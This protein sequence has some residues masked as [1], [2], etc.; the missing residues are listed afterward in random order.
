M[1]DETTCPVCG[2]DLDETDWLDDPGPTYAEMTRTN[3]IWAVAHYLAHLVQQN[4][5]NPWSEAG[6]TYRKDPATGTI[7]RDE[8]R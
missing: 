8:P 6:A 1:L 7:I 4:Q 3:A 2:K 5:R